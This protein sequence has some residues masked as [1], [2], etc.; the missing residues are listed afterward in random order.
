MHVEVAYLFIGVFIYL[1]GYLNGVL[2]PTLESS[3]IYDDDMMEGN[4][5]YDPTH[6]AV[7]SLHVGTEGNSA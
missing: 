5:C 7:R 2:H 1:F 6:T 4:S 3:L